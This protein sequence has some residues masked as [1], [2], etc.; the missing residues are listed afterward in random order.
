MH[1]ISYFRTYFLQVHRG[2]LG[3]V[4]GFSLPT[5]YCC[6]LFLFPDTGYESFP[7]GKQAWCSAA[8]RP[9]QS[10]L[11]NVSFPFY[12]VCSILQISHKCNLGQRL[13]RGRTEVCTR[14]VFKC[15]YLLKPNEGTELIISWLLKVFIFSI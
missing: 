14:L 13:H 15:A 3:I 9:W 12:S 7:C 1:F 10:V 6:P 8:H 2:H 11:K 4:R 5:P